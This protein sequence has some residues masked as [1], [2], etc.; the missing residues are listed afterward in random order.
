MYK[1]NIDFCDTTQNFIVEPTLI[2]NEEDYNNFRINTS[3]ILKDDNIMFITNDNQT[4]V[5]DTKLNGL[6]KKTNKFNVIGK[7]FRNWLILKDFNQLTVY[8]Y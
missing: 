4:F 8:S 5:Y 6:V 3:M 7:T 1:F 2:I